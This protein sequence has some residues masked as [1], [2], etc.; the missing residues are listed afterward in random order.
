MIGATAPCD[1]LWLQSMPP[2]PGLPWLPLLPCTPDLPLQCRD[3]TTATSSLLLAAASPLLRSLLSCTS[4]SCLLLPHTPL[5]AATSLLEVLAT[6]HTRVAGEALLEVMELASMLGL[7]ALEVE[8]A[9]GV[10]VEVEGMPEEVVEKKVEVLAPEMKEKM[11]VMDHNMVVDDKITCSEMEHPMDSGHS[12]EPRE[13]GRS[14]KVTIME[15][16]MDETLIECEKVVDALSTGKVLIAQKSNVNG[17]SRNNATD[18]KK[19]VQKTKCHQCLSCAKAFYSNAQLQEHLRRHEGRPG[20]CCDLCGKAFYRKDCLTG[21][22][23][24]VHA[25][26]KSF[27]CKFCDK[28]FANSYKLSRHSKVHNNLKITKPPP[29]R[30]GVVLSLLKSDCDDTKLPP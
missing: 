9:E 21:H 26:E 19:H 1:T 30:N 20:Y 6:G 24:S 3:G 22:T 17:R 14:T 2:W 18:K 8:G 29:R 28:K 7:P 15:K 10:Q 16:R 13:E 25:K 27:S 4:S 23:K 11:T 12:T 5:A